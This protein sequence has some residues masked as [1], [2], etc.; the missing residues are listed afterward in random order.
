MR[1]FR[2]FASGK[3]IFLKDKVKEYKVVNIKNIKFN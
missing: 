2:G 3:N 1:K